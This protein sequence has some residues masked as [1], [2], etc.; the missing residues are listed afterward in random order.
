MNAGMFGTRPKSLVPLKKVL[1]SQDYEIVTRHLKEGWSFYSVYRKIGISERRL[2][3]FAREDEKLR[4]IRMT[5]DPGRYRK[6][7]AS[8]T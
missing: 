7:G 3:Q 2:L 6:Y 1:T 4:T 5:Y 8:K